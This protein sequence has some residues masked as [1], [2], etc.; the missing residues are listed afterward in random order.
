MSYQSKHYLSLSLLLLSPFLFSLNLY[1]KK[2]SLKSST[3]SNFLLFQLANISDTVEAFSPLMRDINE[4]K[5]HLRRLHRLES[6][7]MAPSPSRPSLIARPPLLCEKSHRYS[8]TT[9]T[10]QALHTFEETVKASRLQRCETSLTEAAD[11]AR[12]GR[13]V[14]SRCCVRWV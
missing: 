2:T 14:R 5:N 4:P 13:R 3:E 11:C 10:C 8:S 12:L 7:M 9:R 6:S 1:I